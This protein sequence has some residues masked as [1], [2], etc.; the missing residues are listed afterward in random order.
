MK[1]HPMTLRLK[2]NSNDH[3]YETRRVGR[4][5]GSNPSWG[6]RFSA[7]A[8]TRPARPTQPPVQWALFLPRAQRP[9]RAV[10]RLPPF[11]AEVKERVELYPDSQSG[12]S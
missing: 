8:Q 1:L 3:Y 2:Y 9:G 6:V 5:G 11:T 7:P 10:D 12:T 4:S